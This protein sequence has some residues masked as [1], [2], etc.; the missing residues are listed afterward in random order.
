M[1]GYFFEDPVVDIEQITGNKFLKK[2][3]TAE[4]KALLEATI[5]KLDNLTDWSE[6]ALQ[7]ALNELLA[8]SGKK[9]AEFFSLVRI[10]VS[11]APFSPAL[12]QTLNVLGKDTTIRRLKA[13]LEAL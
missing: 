1:T 11:F 13:T 7:N 10:A 6:E 8:A 9:P 2:L 12:H 5:E 4:L 3:E